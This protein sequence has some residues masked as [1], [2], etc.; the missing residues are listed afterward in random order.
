MSSGT[1]RSTAKITTEGTTESERFAAIQKEAADLSAPS[2]APS[3][4]LPGAVP[5]TEPSSD[6]A[7]QPEPTSEPH[8]DEEDGDDP[9]D[10]PL[11]T[12]IMA[13][14][15]KAKV[16]KGLADHQRLKGPDN[17][18]QWTTAMKMAFYTYDCYD[19]MKPVLSMANLKAETSSSKF[20]S[21]E[22]DLDDRSPNMVKLINAN[23]L[24]LA[25]I[26]E[27][28]QSYC[29]GLND[30]IAAWKKLEAWCQGTGPVQR[31]V[32]QREMNTLKSGDFKTADDFVNKFESLRLR[33]KTLGRDQTDDFWIDQFICS[34]E[35]QFP[36]WAAD[37]R[38]AL[39]FNPSQATLAA[40]QSDLADEAKNKAKPP[41]SDEM[42]AFASKNKGKGK[43]KKQGR[44]RYKPGE[45][46]HTNHPADKCWI[47]HPELA[48]K[49]D[50]TSGDSK[51]RE[52]KP[53]EKTKLETTVFAEEVMSA[54]YLTETD[55]EEPAPR[56]SL[57]EPIQKPGTPNEAPKEPSPWAQDALLEHTDPVS[58]SS[59][60]P[61]LAQQDSDSSSQDRQIIQGPVE[62]VYSTGPA[63]KSPRWKGDSGST[64]HIGHTLEDFE[65]LDHSRPLAVIRTGSGLVKPTAV[66]TVRKEVRNSEGDTVVMTLTE[67]Y[68]IP[69][70]PV[71]IFSLQRFYQKGGRI[72]DFSLVDSAGINAGS[73]D[74]NFDLQVQGSPKP[75]AEETLICT[76]SEKVI[77][78]PLWHARL[79][80]I[81]RKAIRQTAKVTNGMWANKESDLT[82]PN[83][84]C[85]PCDDAKNLRYTPKPGREIPRLAGE[86]WHLD[87]V[88]IQYPGGQGE[89]WA[90]IL[91]E[92]KTGFRTTDTFEDK[93]QC[94]QALINRIRYAKRQWQ[95]PIR[96]II[97]DGGNE[98]Y[99][100]HNGEFDQLIKDQGIEVIKSAPY[101]PEDNGV[102]ERSNRI[103][104]EKTRTWMIA[105]K[106]DPRLWPWFWS[107]AVEYTNYLCVTKGD[108]SGKPRIEAFLDEN[109]P[110]KAHNVDLTY[111]RIPGSKVKVHIPK[112]RRDN[113]DKFGPT[114]EDGILLGW[115]GKTIYTVYLPNRPGHFTQRIVNTSNLVFYE[116]VGS[117]VMETTVSDPTAETIADSITVRPTTESVVRRTLPPNAR[118]M[119]KQKP[120]EALVASCFHISDLAEVEPLTLAQALSGPVHME[121]LAALYDEMRN[122]LR[123]K[124][125]RATNRTPG[126]RALTPKLVFRNKYGKDGNV[127]KRK[128]RLVA[129]GFEQIEGIDYDQTFAAVAKACTWR[130][131]LALAASYNWEIHQID[132]VAAFLN[133]EL[134]EHVEMEV[135][136]GMAEF[137]AKFP[138]ENTIGFDPNTDQI[139]K[140][141][142]S[143]YGLK[144]AP[145]QWQ[146]AL[147][148]SLQQ[149]GF[150]QLKSDPAVYIMYEKKLIVCTF[151][152]VRI[153]RDRAQRKIWL[154]Q[155]AYLKRV[156]EAKEYTNSRPAA[157]PIAAVA[158]IKAWPNEGQASKEDILQYSSLVGSQ[159]HLMT[160]SRPDIAF[161][162]S[163]VSRYNHNPSADNLHLANYCLKYLSGTQNL[164]LELGGRRTLPSPQW[165][166]EE[167]QQP[168]RQQEG[169]L[170]IVIWTDSDFKGDK[171]T[172]R[173]TYGYIVQVEGS[174][175]HWK[176][177]RAPR[178]MTSTTEAEYHAIM[179]GVQQGLFY[180]S[181]FT[182]LRIPINLT[183]KSDNQGSIKLTRN[184]EFHERTM[185]IPLEEH[186]VRDEVD[187]G[188]V[189]ISWVPTNDQVADGLT[190]PL[191]REKHQRMLQLLGLRDVTES[192]VRL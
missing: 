77:D 173:S 154:T 85:E 106:A 146:K 81:G 168:A 149:L 48:P 153:I 137:F 15:S 11:T 91:T 5:A 129:R 120:L 180:K 162:M 119:Q 31:Q 148:K 6:P 125:F 191:T 12:I 84:I 113:A 136:P 143:L 4:D 43:G 1:T 181:L 126:Q 107:T 13:S 19:V 127:E 192:G 189:T 115:K 79:G 150:T 58:E 152:G 63:K 134:D 55:P 87:S 169:N 92:A 103:I 9:S 118:K 102:A 178:V 53:K 144:Q 21:T 25:S 123:N 71:N 30:P 70:F 72:K 105:S 111:L 135:P 164:G 174:T 165:D 187:R 188:T 145:R 140:V 35:D 29:Q 61:M 23:T 163:V 100:S 78:Y 93:G 176:S 171:S 34:A 94:N 20:S 155:D 36:S 73:F 65:D 161:T 33:L 90:I 17:Y 74:A 132:I 14:D 158:L 27:K 108:E 18:P 28:A 104:I 42:T 167:F 142:K 37:H 88:H 182:E 184:P 170:D 75:N 83:T 40:I 49:R 190:K 96:R 86:E 101:T 131:L 114:G 159:M 41:K 10:P 60:G 59:I 99:G 7:D 64:C 139:L 39:R 3:P 68:Y 122:M 16:P 138:K 110:G 26:S 151:L 186:F 51:S 117:K 66:G 47:D 54:S 179:K 38:R 172:M 22:L 124:V 62:E 166:N 2:T 130:I 116:Q 141:L 69:T 112:E 24:I 156:L 160:Y 44:K 157:T 50:S 128:V 185:H 98:L 147:K 109:I 56:L 8:D 80:H 52:A 177:K 95:I 76:T 57:G 121:W 97:M 67:V 32:A 133:G 183:I 82:P 175:V 89:F 45:C 46:P